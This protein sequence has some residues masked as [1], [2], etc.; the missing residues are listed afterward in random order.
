MIQWIQKKMQ[1]DKQYYLQQQANQIEKENAAEQNG[2]DRAWFH[3]KKDRHRTLGK[4][5]A[6]DSKFSFR[7]RKPRF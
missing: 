7:K 1:Q 4:K 2:K 5:V 6:R 3:A